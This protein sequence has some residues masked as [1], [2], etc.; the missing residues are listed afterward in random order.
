MDFVERSRQ[1]VGEGFVGGGIAHNA[2][3]LQ[4]DVFL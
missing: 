4:N 1:L 3:A 2:L